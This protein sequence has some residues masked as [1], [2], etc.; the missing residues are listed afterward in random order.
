M[1]LRRLL[2]GCV[3]LSVAAAAA[4][5]QS[6]ETGKRAA[7]KRLLALAK[8][9]QDIDTIF[10]RLIDA[11]KGPSGEAMVANLRARGLFKR[12]TAEQAPEMEQLVRQTSDNIFEGVKREMSRQVCT[13]ENLEAATAPVLDK[14][15]SAAEVNE[16]VALFESPLGRK[17]SELY[18]EVTAEV[19]YEALKANG[20]FDVPT[21]P[22]EA[23]P[24]LE[25][26]VK[27]ARA[28]FEPAIAVAVLRRLTADDLKALAAFN[29]TPL[30]GKLQETF[31]K[32][33]E[34]I[35]R[36]LLQAH[37]PRIL[38]LSTQ[39]REAEM[40][41]FLPRAEEIL[42]QNRGRAGKAAPRR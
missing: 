9:E 6:G 30:G 26:A 4:A 19:M 22:A 29:D 23:L 20:A 17:V 33:H 40:K 39:A 13:P 35:Y 27:N 7:I 16:L 10:R 42:R 3:I 28:G 32:M 2:V 37:A 21:S 31:P 25:R 36:A 14:Y 18:P 38:E 12:F 34:E 1:L 24:K 5:R 15:L 8:P 11:Y 41:L